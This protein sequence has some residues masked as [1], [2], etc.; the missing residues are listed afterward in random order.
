[1]KKFILLLDVALLYAALA[2]TV[3]IRYPNEFRVQLD[4]HAPPFTLIFVIWILAFYIGNLYND[5]I[6]RNNVKFYSAL[7]SASLIAAG[8]SVAFFYLIPLYGI[9]P[10]TNLFIF[11]GIFGVLF[12]AARIF[13]N[14]VR[15]KKF[16]KLLMLVG[17]NAQSLELAKFI[18]DNP[19]LG[20]MLH[21][22]IDIS[23]QNSLPLLDE[24]LLKFGIIREIDH[25]RHALSAEKIHTVVVSAQAYQSAELIDLFF[26]ALERGITFQN[27][28]YFYEQ[29]TGRVP[30]DAINQI[31]F[32][33]NINEGTKKFYE[34]VKR[35]TDVAMAAILA[36]PSAVMFPLLA[37]LIKIDSQ[38]PVFYRQQRVGKLG[39]PFE[40]IKFRTMHKDAESKS[41]A[42]WTQEN[43]PRITRL[44]SFLRKSRIDELPQIWNILKGEMSFI[45]PR[46]ERPEFH[47]TLVRELPFYEERYL[48]KP[49]ATGWA[50]L[51]KSYYSSVADTKEKL[52]Y[53][54]YYIK[55]RSLLLDIDILLRTINLSLRQGG[56]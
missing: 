49:G 20:Y 14:D 50:Q 38:G 34:W 54:L 30:L 15:E 55:N 3:F 47:Q 22:V 43:D 9:T 4:L 5:S 56:R 45:G 10:K 52:Q 17:V 35:V 12:S 48:V 32:L 19:Q 23:P 39:Q 27:L 26:R 46:A 16:K 13:L 11:L 8:F 40:M 36:V 1:M 7:S 53:D 44:G 42:V 31:W 28:A 24:D 2:A 37:I 6:L 18:K 21:S 29:V 51:Q 41:G 25:V 33:A